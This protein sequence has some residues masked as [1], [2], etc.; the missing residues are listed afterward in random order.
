MLYSTYKS[1]WARLCFAVV[2]LQPN[3]STSYKVH[4]AGAS[5]WRNCDVNKS[6]KTDKNIELYKKNKKKQKTKKRSI[7]LK[8]PRAAYYV[9][10]S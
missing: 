10:V 8:M 3:S 5:A 6:D 1:I 2:R 7:E 9:S 4:F